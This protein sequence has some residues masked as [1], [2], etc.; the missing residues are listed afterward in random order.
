M[1]KLFNK[2]LIAVGLKRADCV[3]CGCDPKLGNPKGGTE[4]ST[5]N[6]KLYY[7]DHINKD[8]KEYP[9]DVPA[10][11]EDIAFLQDQ[12]FKKTPPKPKMKEIKAIATKDFIETQK[13]ASV[14]KKNK[15]KPKKKVYTEPPTK[16]VK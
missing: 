8:G 9:I 13:R 16:K 14:E 4:W 10:T 11:D 6:G 5:Q 2:F 7:S 1:K 15:H 3:N 12:L